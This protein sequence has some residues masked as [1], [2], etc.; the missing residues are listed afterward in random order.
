MSGVVLDEGVPPK[1]WAVDAYT[2][3][4][5]TLAVTLYISFSADAER[6]EMRRGPNLTILPV[7]FQP[8][9]A[10]DCEEMFLTLLLVQAMEVEMSISFGY[11]V[12][13][14]PIC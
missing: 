12:D 14:I 10:A 4:L 7:C 11:V 3:D 5:L 6:T 8:D 13:G 2:S 1:K 9:T